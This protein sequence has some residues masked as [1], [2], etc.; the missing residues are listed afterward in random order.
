MPGTLKKT[1][2]TEYL[3]SVS[4]ATIQR[5][6]DGRRFTAYFHYTRARDRLSTSDVRDDHSPVHGLAGD[7]TPTRPY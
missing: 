2:L 4:D 1:V 3:S 6:T 5:M 7:D